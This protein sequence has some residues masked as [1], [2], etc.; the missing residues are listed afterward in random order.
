MSKPPLGR[1][2][3]YQFC[4]CLAYSIAISVIWQ[5]EVMLSALLGGLAII[6]ANAWYIW[7]LQ[8]ITLGGETER[9]LAAYHRAEI[10]KLAFLAL[11][12]TLILLADRRFSAEVEK[13]ALNTTVLFGSFLLSSVFVTLSNAWELNRWLNQQDDQT[14]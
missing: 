1:L 11:L 2:I 12:M 13:E 3:A 6:L 9:V 7:R 4:F 10:G 5:A 14:N 8:A